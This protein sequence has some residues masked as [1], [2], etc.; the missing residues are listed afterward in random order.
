MEQP[1]VHLALSMNARNLFFTITLRCKAVW[2]MPCNIRQKCRERKE[3]ITIIPF[4]VTWEHTEVTVM[5]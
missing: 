4:E 3:E 2:K 5:G 1:V